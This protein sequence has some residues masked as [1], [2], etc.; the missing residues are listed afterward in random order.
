[1]ADDSQGNYTRPP[2]NWPQ[3]G[4][5]AEASQVNVPVNDLSAAMSRRLMRDGRAPMLGNLNMNGHRVIGGGPAAAGGDYVTLAQVQSMVAALGLVPTG[6]MGPISGNAIPAGWVRANGQSLSRT[7]YADL[8]AY[9]QTSGNLA[10]SDAAK[11]HGQYGPGNGSTT[12]TVPN[13]EADGGYFIR[14]V[15]SGRGI[16]SV[17]AEDFK[18]HSHSGSISPAGEHSHLLHLP[19]ASSITSGG[20][21]V[22]GVATSTRALYSTEPA[23]GHSHSVSISGTGGTETRPKNIAYPV[24]I[25]A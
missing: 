5:L 10:A 2:G 13:L 12:F 11:T 24:I 20:G 14:P 16:G 19:Q 18:A 22:P 25:K 7:T 3:D 17:Q 1:M 6:F 15:S 9:A 23:G 4:Q 21:V 8:W